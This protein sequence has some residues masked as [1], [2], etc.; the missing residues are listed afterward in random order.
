L[1]VL[2]IRTND[3]YVIPLDVINGLPYLKMQSHTDTEWNE[4]LCDS[5][6]NEWDLVSL[7][8]PPPPTPTGTTS[9]KRLDDGLMA[10]T[11]TNTYKSRHI[12]DPVV[13]LEPYS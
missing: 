11:L 3:G 9:S 6:G 13:I 10:T 2:S 12:P 7:I 8:T 5:H 4:L 1:A